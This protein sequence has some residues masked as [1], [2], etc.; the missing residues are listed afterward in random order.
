M[1]LNTQTIKHKEH[2]LPDYLRCEAIDIA[3]ITVIWMES[4]WSQMNSKKKVTKFL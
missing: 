3:V 2:L 4:G 1:L